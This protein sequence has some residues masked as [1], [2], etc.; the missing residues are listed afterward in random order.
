MSRYTYKPYNKALINLNRL[1]I[2][3]KYQT[4]VFYVRTLPYGL[5]SVR[6]VN[7]SF[8]YFP[9]MTALSAN[10]KRLIVSPVI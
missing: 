1:V 7:T 2:T 3:G 10:K 4:S 5:A 6:T 9:V 8:W